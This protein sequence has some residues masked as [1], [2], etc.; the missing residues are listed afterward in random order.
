[1]SGPLARAGRNL[2]QKSLGEAAARLCF[3]LLFIL[4]ARTLGAAEFG[5]FSYASALAGLAFIGSDLGLS[6]LVVRDGA[7]RPDRV[8]ELAGTAAVLKAALGALVLGGIWAFAAFSGRGQTGI[9][10]AV[11]L[12][13]ALWSA[14]ELGVAGLNALERMDLEARVKAAGRLVSLLLAGGALIMGWGL[15]GFVLGLVVSN[16]FAAILSFRLLGRRV[17]LT[18]RL[19]GARLGGMLGRALPL[20]LV[21]VF[22]LVY[23]RVDMVMLEMMGVGYREIGWY[24]AAVRVV[25]AVGVLPGMAAGAMLPVLSGLAAGPPE[26]FARLYRQGQRF[27]LALG[28]P[29]AVGLWLVRRPLTELVFGREFAPAAAALAWLGPALGV[30][31]LN[32]LQIA[33]LTALGRQRAAAWATG[34]CVLVNVGL[35]LAAIPRWGFAGAAAATLVT[36]TALLAACL[37]VLGRALGGTGFW[38]GLWRPVLAA[39]I[40]GLVLLLLPAWPLWALA[41]AGAAVY[42]GALAALG[43]VPWGLARRLLAGRDPEAV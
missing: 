39:G 30:V 42:A 32:H 16:L 14:S 43:G 22:I 27:L 35:N 31:F 25:D 20:A 41:P 8:G 17:R 34:A 2:A 37:A 10:M 1:M 6:T 33:A 15:W 26:G 28:L 29:A 19:D 11:A 18:P 40:M 3:L 12:A 9:I 4:A 24:A 21:S 36:E 5:L 23:V 7:R 13:A 38:S